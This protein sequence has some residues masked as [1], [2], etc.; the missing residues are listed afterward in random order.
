[1]NQAFNNV[2]IQESREMKR[3]TEAAV[4]GRTAMKQIS[5][6]T[7]VYSR[8]IRGQCECQGYWGS[9]NNYSHLLVDSYSPHF[10]HH[11]DLFVIPDGPS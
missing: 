4:R 11:M 7:M 6:P 3:I 10:R 5:Y 9:L 2:T 8:N 1:M